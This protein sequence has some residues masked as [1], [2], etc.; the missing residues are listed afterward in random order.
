MPLTGWEQLINSGEYNQENAGSVLSNSS[1]LTDITPGGSA[2]NV[3]QT[4]QIPGSYLYPGMQL[5]VRARGVASSTGTTTLSLGVYWAG[6]AGTALTNTSSFAASANMSNAP[7]KLDADLRVSTVG[8][9]ASVYAAAEIIG[10]TTSGL[11]VVG[12]SGASGLSNT[13]ASGTSA[14]LTV[15]AQWGA[16]AAGNSIQL[17]QYM[18]E[19]LN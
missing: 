4:L 12:S 11:Q 5:R 8:P 7:W 19:Q 17:L 9:A 6:V 2:T 3:G 16:A 15:G 18:V 10:L 14:I 1:V 13:F